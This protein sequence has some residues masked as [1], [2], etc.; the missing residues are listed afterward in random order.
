MS[1]SMLTVSEVASM[2]GVSRFAVD[3]WVR[4]GK[5]TA[6]WTSPKRR[7]IYQSEVDRFVKE[8][9]LVVSA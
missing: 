1:K 7:G 2:F 4:T 6:V 5:I 3:Q 8:Y 9:G